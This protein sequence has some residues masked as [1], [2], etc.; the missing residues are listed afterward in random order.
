MEELTKAQKSRIAIRSFKTTADALSLRGY[1]KPAGRSGQTLSDAL[2]MLSPEIYGSMN[3][4]RIIELKGLEYVIDRLPRGIEECR[5]I[6]LT[7]QEDLGE[8]TF[9][10]IF[11]LKRRR[12]SYRVSENEICFVITRGQSEIYDILTHITF[13]NIE[14]G[15]I[16][17]QI[18][19]KDDRIRPEWHS[20]QETVTQS[21]KLSDEELDK[22]IWNL[23][24]ILGRTYQETRET[25]AYLE[26]NRQKA[27]A[28]SGLF[29]IIYSLGKCTAEEGL[30]RENML[31]I[32]FT[33]SLTDMIGHQKCGKQWAAQIYEILAQKKLTQR[34]LHVISANLHSVV[35]LLFAYAALNDHSPQSVEPEIYQFVNDIRERA[36][37][38]KTFAYEHGLYEIRDYSGAQIDVQI[39]DTA[40]MSG[41]AFHPQI[42]IESA[43]VEK[44]KPVLVVMD[45]AFGAQ[46]YELMDELLN[47][48]REGLPNDPLNIRS[49]SVMGKAG[50]LTGSMFD[51]MLATAHVLEGTAH[52]YIVDNDLTRADFDDD[53]D[54]YTGPIVTVLG[55]SLQNCDVLERFQ[56]TSWKA[57][58]LEM[59]GGHYQRAINAAIVREHIPKEV[60]VRYAYYAS[61]NPLVSGQTLASGGMGSEGI[62]PTYMITKVILEKILKTQHPC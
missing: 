33:P 54:V 55:T 21:Q 41:M 29:H 50:I 38:T 18:R 42:Q 37:E 46:A 36:S 62:K 20:L 51:I 58:G 48:L 44:T 8:T 52:N 57:I 2:K 45:Y 60:K 53:V 9:E 16:K 47:P 23:S 34:P 56:S 3:D 19:N 6:V 24:M 11:P 12:T 35:N 31:E 26:E 17:N 39:I 25:Y 32:F 10:K 14:A 28:N 1:Y 15:K 22:A 59:E 27:N 49:I 30:V 7:A 40:H 4:P 61:D 5:R 43:R 13:L